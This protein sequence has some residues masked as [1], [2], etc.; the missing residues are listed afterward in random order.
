MRR[1]RHLAAVLAVGCL[2]GCSGAETARPRHVLLVV[3]DTLRADRLGS[4]GAAED[5]SPNLDGFARAARVFER[6]SAHAADTRFSVASLMT[7][8]LPH[9]TRI[10]ERRGLPA[11]VTTWAEVLREHGFR[12]EAVVSNYVL[13][14]GRGFEQGFDRYDDELEE[15]ELVRRSP[16]RTAARTT[17]RAIERLE[18]LASGPPFFLWVHYQDPHGPY[19]PPSE[20]VRD[21]PP[22]APVPPSG[23]LSGRGGI[24]TYQELAGLSDP[25]AYVRR[26]EGEVRHADRELRRLFDALDRLG[27]RDD[28]LIVFTS[29]H[30]EGLGEHAYYFAHGEYLYEHQIHVPLLL[31]WGDRLRGREARPVQHLD[32]L[33]TVLRM[34]GIPSDGL[35][36]H[37]LLADPREREILSVMRS[38]LVEDEWKFSLVRGDWKLIHTPLGERSELYALDADPG[39]RED[40]AARPGHRARRDRMRADLERLR[41]LDRISPGTPRSPAPTA[42]E[43]ERL[44]A[45]GYVE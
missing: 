1:H 29:D 18:A 43:R 26:Y 44:R 9:E 20:M 38:P 34:L 3:V 2:L 12:S 40:L 10:L 11:G 30:G 28:T 6:C 32:V 37:D 22:G 27:L 33:P 36:G 42:D 41:A 25:G 16:E 8:F 45:L 35:P 14:R 15:K 39:E 7:G 19:T 31:A 5:A 4:Y 24:P 23:S 21:G 17:D 13:R